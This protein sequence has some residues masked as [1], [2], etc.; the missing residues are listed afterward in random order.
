LIQQAGICVFIGGFRR[1]D[2]AVEPALG[3]LQESEIALAEGKVL[4][5]IAATGGA[6]AEIWTR[7][8]KNGAGG[9]SEAIR[10]Y[11]PKARNALDVAGRY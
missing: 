8:K 10:G 1:I 5:P 7:I 6:A 3:V 11:F 4:I 9:V 2:G